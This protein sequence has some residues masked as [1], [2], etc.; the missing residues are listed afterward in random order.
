MPRKHEDTENNGGTGRFDIRDVAKLAGVSVAT[1]SRTVNNIP[2]VNVQM[3]ARV[4]EAIRELNYYPNG[5]AR[6]LVSGKSRLVGLLVS[7]ITNPFFPELIKCFEKAAVE[8]G[9][10]LLIGST[11]Y[12]SELQHCLRRMIERNVDGVAVMTFGVEDPVLD[13]LSERKIPMVFVDVSQETFP[14]DALMVDY[15]H[16]MAEAIRHLV[17]LGHVDI[18]FISGPLNQHSALLRRDAF[19]LSLEECGCTPKAAFI[20]EGDHR[21]EGGMHGIATLLQT[22]HPPTAVLC[23]NDMMAIG[24]LRTLH[25][26]GFRVPEDMS[27]VGFDDIHLA[28]FVNPPLTTV[29]MSRAEI[30]REAVKALLGRIESV[31]E[32]GRTTNQPIP[33]KL[34][35]RETTAPPRFQQS[36]PSS[37]PSAG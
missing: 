11:N 33:T 10:E 18:G 12:D 9:Y 17:A 8:H 7:D 28:E 24:A 13:E 37:T 36:R 3:A 29:S 15:K 14:Q 16:G 30:A 19:L 5:Q 32:H 35:V 34:I 4:R 1:V 20:T 31:A 25:K 27:I 21:L 23:S 22:G 26:R 2:T 6:A